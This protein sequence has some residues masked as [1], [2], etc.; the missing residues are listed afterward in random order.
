[1]LGQKHLKALA[2][3]LADEL[4]A[5]MQLVGVLDTHIWQKLMAIKFIPSSKVQF[6]PVTFS[7]ELTGLGFGTLSSAI[8]DRNFP[9]GQQM[10][11]IV[12]ADNG[13]DTDMGEAG[14]PAQVHAPSPSADALSTVQSADGD[15]EVAAPMGQLH[16]G[17]QSPLGPSHLEMGEWKASPMGQAE[18]DK[19]IEDM[20]PK[21]DEDR[22]DD[23]LSLPEVNDAELPDVD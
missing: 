18:F 12:A 17:P 23:L 3:G 6:D 15:E 20:Y 16:I 4:A 14:H 9:G 19:T 21:S 13:G 8:Q 2:K 7:Q 22:E 1:M 11:R 10:A 5:L